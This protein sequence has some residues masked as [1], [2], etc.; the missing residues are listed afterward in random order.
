MLRPSRKPNLLEAS[1]RA[2]LL[3]DDVPV[4][5]IV[6]IAEIDGRLSTRTPL[7]RPNVQCLPYVREAVQRLELHIAILNQLAADDARKIR[8]A[9]A[10]VEVALLSVVLLPV[11]CAFLFLCVDMVG[12]SVAASQASNAA[13]SAAMFGAQSSSNAS[14]TTAMQALA[15]ANAP[16]LT[17]FTATYDTSAKRLTVVVTMPTYA[18]SPGVP[19]SYTATAVYPVP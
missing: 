18:S 9:A 1:V 7:F 5:V 6:P 8:Q 12:Y 14:N 15:V 11:C 13:T 3:S 19:T 4:N 2:F 16:Q 17:A 10:S